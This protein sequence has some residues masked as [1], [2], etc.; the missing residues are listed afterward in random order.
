LV[1]AEDI[2]LN[3]RVIGSSDASFG[4]NLWVGGTSGI[5]VT[6]AINAGSISSGTTA[7]TQT[8][9]DNSTKLAT[10]A[11]VQ[12]QGYLTTATAASTY[13]PKANPTFTGT[14]NTGTLTS[15]GTITGQTLNLGGATSTGN[16]LAVGGNVLITGNAVINNSLIVTGGL[17]L[18]AGSVTAGMLSTTYI[19]AASPTF[20]GTTTFPGSTTINSSGYVGIGTTNPQAALDVGSGTIQTVAVNT[21]RVKNQSNQTLY[22]QN[23]AT[24][25][26]VA[27]GY[28]GSM[29]NTFTGFRVYGSDGTAST[30]NTF[31]VLNNGNVGIGIT[32]PQYTLDVSAASATAPLR[33]Q[34]GGTSALVVDGTGR[35][36]IGTTNPTKMLTVAGDAL[37]NGL[38]V[39]LGAG[40]VSTNTAVGIY[41]LNANI[42]ADGNTG[43]GREALRNT[44]TGYQ[45]TA[46]GCLALLQNTGGIWNTAVGSQALRNTTGQYNTGLGIQSGLNN[47]Q[48][49]AAYNTFLG[50]YADLDSSANSWSTSTA[51]GAGAIIT[52]SNQ[53][54]LGT[55]SEKVYIP[56]YVGIG[57]NP[58]SAL[59]V[60]GAIR[61]SGGITPTY[62]SPSFSAGQIGYQLISTTILNSSASAAT[63]TNI[64]TLPQSLTTGVWL[65]I[66]RAAINGSNNVYGH[67]FIGTP[68]FDPNT[69]IYAALLGGSSTIGIS[70]SQVYAL[71]SNTTINGVIWSP[72]SMG[73]YGVMLSATRIA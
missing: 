5:T 68:S 31:V 52:G 28:A 70:T 19:S 32:I 72:Y 25:G 24:G 15:S 55:S 33:V 13:A 49:G 38:T 12:N 27:V 48:S 10:T 1:V 47:K 29:N 23:D 20:S 64:V 60:T 61:V 34:I 46:V 71:T 57:A 3:G 14:T 17:S 6:G 43:I 18:P 16:A 9:T 44:T 30:K 36:G 41:A 62:S 26:D 8:S 58:Q 35:F 56:G 22:L 11:Y 73:V 40:A 7:T 2:S 21:S 66:A 63:Y 65:I 39:G 45:N 50:A 69:D 54:V 4:G 53:I 51:I 67:L 37:V 42:T 59:D